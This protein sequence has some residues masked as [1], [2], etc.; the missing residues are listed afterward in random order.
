MPYLRRMFTSL[1]SNRTKLL[2]SGVSN[3]LTVFA[4]AWRP[5]ESPNGT[6]SSLFRATSKALSREPAGHGEASGV[7][8]LP[9]HFVLRLRRPRLVR[10]I[11]P[12]KPRSHRQR[13][14]IE[15][16]G[17]PPLLKEMRH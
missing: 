10:E 1:S 7:E 4:H 5:L 14:E 3:C 12:T 8:C 15:R 11:L 2:V 6:C 16:R 13:T 17:I 9:D